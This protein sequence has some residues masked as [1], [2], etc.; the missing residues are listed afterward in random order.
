[1]LVGLTWG[2]VGVWPTLYRPFDFLGSPRLKLIADIFFNRLSIE[3]WFKMI[4]P[5]I[6]LIDLIPWFNSLNWFNS[7]IYYYY[8]QSLHLAS[9]RLAL[10][11]ASLPLFSTPG[12]LWRLIFVTPR[13]SWRSFLGPWAPCGRPWAPCLGS[14]APQDPPRPPQDPPRAPQGLPALFCYQTPPLWQALHHGSLNKILFI[15]RH[16]FQYTRTFREFK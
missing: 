10:W 8:S 1:M 11:P 12:F 7:L 9:S 14:K 13:C 3:L 15:E 16:A 6:D 5:W 4:V 2:L